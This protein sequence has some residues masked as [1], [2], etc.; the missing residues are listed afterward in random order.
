MDEGFLKF[1]ENW[2]STGA[3][4]TDADCY[5]AYRFEWNKIGFRGA[6]SGV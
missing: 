2:R 6:V 3:K 5:R 4:C 1:M